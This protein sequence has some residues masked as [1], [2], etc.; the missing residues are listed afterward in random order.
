[1]EIVHRAAP[2]RNVPV[3]FTLDLMKPLFVSRVER[4]SPD[5]DSAEVTLRSEQG[6][7]VAFCH[8]CDVEAGASVPN[9]LHVLDGDLKAAFLSDWPDDVRS[10]RSTERMERTGPFSYRGV[11]LVIDQSKG[12]VQALGFVLDFGA[13]PCDGPVEFECLR[14]DL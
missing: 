9:R 10:E 13:A 8:P 7:L 1:L 5:D 12:L 3:T 14:V 11:G 4:F 6:E 2:C